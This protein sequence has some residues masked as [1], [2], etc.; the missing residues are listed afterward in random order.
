M[1]LR[2]CT[3]LAIAFS[4]IAFSSLRAQDVRH[5]EEEVGNLRNQLREIH[6]R[7]SLLEASNRKLAT[8]NAELRDLLSE[9]ANQE[10]ALELRVNALLDDVQ[11][12]ATAVVSEANPIIVSAQAR[13]RAGYT[14]NRDFGR[15]FANSTFEDD[16][17]T[18][19][20]ARFNLAFKFQVSEHV[21]THFEVIATGLFDNG[22]ANPNAGNLD[23][24]NLY[25][26]F[27]EH[28][29]LF[30]RPELGMKLGRQEIVLGNEFHFGN[31]DFFAGET[32]D[33][34][35][36]W[37]TS[38]D[39]T[40]A[41]IWAKQGVDNNFNPSNHPYVPA[42]QG[43]G[44][45]DDEYLAA[46]LTLNVI[47]DTVIDLYYIFWD[48][49]RGTSTG[50][51]GNLIGA[52]SRTDVHIFGGRIAGVLNL[53]AG[54]DYNAEISYMTGDLTDNNAIDVEGLTSEVTIGLTLNEDNLFRIFASFLYASGV[55]GDDSGWVPLFTERHAQTDW[56]DHTKYM[57]RWGLMD[58]IPFTNVIAV[59]AGFTFRPRE[60]WILGATAIY[61]WHDE[62]VTTIS[63][64]SDD[65]IGFEVDVFVE[66]Q[67]SENTS[68][69]LGFGLFFPEEGAPLGNGAIGDSFTSSSA[70]DVA[71]LIYLQ[72]LVTF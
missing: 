62:D 10:D 54:L 55:D 1:S 69:A 51:L 5:L 52:G 34:A 8:D 9:T 28:T 21:S 35:L 67:H 61:A 4:A 22:S 16:R 43:N 38:E 13:V 70:D 24:I 6:Q 12:A 17:G 31:N 72:S 32:F 48:G 46:Y 20:D 65:G 30:G 23:D 56:N 66:H 64:S 19:I 15:D 36:G 18:F 42:G 40:L 14:A 53:A 47:E 68:F 33:A 39:F 71:A 11:G 45:D 27:I 63:G 41:L 25:Q 26:G 57:A 37:W 44:H 29:H 2:H 49:A 7:Q 3:V 58:I 59:Q 60:D 50:T